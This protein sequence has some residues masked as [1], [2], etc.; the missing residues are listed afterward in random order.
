MNT[1]TITGKLEGDP[2]RKETGDSVVTAIRI[3]SGDP[4]PAAAGS[5]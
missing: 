1:I 2:I 5:G 3:A 4:T